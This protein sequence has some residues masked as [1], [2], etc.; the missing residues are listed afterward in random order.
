[1]TGRPLTAGSGGRESHLEFWVTWDDLSREN[2]A[3]AKLLASA[4]LLR[5]AVSRAYYAAYAAVSAKLVG[6]TSFPAG[7]HGPS[8]DRLPKLAMNYLSS[9]PVYERRRVSNASWRLY[10]RRVDS[11]YKPPVVI[12]SNLVRESIQDAAFIIRLVAK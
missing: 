2:L 12:G 4:G 7:R 10:Q 6:K 11:D 9:L 1:M 3:A 8:H 5:S